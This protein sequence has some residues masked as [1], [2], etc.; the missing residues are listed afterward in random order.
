MMVPKSTGVIFRRTSKMLTAPGSIWNEAVSMYTALFENL[1]IRHRE[2]EIIF[3]NGSI[4]KFQHMQHESNAFDHKGG[5]Y[6]LVA[7]DEATDF[8]ETQITFLLS[9]MRNANVNYTPQMFLCT[10]P[11]YHSFIRHWIEDFYLNPV[12]GTPIPERSNTERY[13]VRVG[14]EMKWYNTRGEA[15]AIHG[16]GNQSGIRSFRFIA[17]KI[18]DNPYLRDSDYLSNLMALDRVQRL[19]MLEGSWTARAETTGYWH[20]NHVAIVDKPPVKAKRVMAMDMAFSLPSETTP[21]PDSTAF[22]L[23]S[24]DINSVYT[25]EYVHTMQD[26]VHAVENKIFELA[27]QFGTDIVWSIPCDPNAQAAAYARDLQRRMAEKGYTVKLQKPVKSKLVRFQ[28]FASVTE[29]RFVQVVNA[30]WNKAYFDQLEIFDGLGKHHDDMVDATSDAFY[31][32]N[33]ETTIPSM[34]LPSLN[35]SAP[36]QPSGIASFGLPTVNTNTSFSIPTFNFT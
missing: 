25:I 11:S 28:P 32:L 36:F 22:V 8:T 18:W 1:R 35:K 9:R 33:R 3:P 20:R 7:F 13:F 5:Q 17:A 15:E 16:K 19:I 34:S 27:K 6:S 14:N 4:L 29:A 12:D 2:T 21:D 10:N 30:D 23:M 31:L 24:K 26:R